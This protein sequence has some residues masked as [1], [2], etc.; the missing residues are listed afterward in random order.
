YTSA[1]VVKV[2]LSGP[3]VTLADPGTPVHAAVALSATATDGTAGPASVQFQVSPTG[4]GSW[5]TIATDST[6]VDGFTA[7]FDSTGVGDGQYDFRAIARDA[8]IGR[9][10][11]RESAEDRE[12]GRRL[13]RK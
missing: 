6:P 1:N 5:T 11:C 2:D 7:S 8:E 3:N 13:N 4:A 9:A 10:S 12:S